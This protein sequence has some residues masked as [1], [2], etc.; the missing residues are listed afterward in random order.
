MVKI[1]NESLS[2]AV[3]SRLA[4]LKKDSP[5]QI[6]FYQLVLIGMC[7]DTGQG[8]RYFASLCSS[9]YQQRAEVPHIADA[10][11]VKPSQEYKQ[12]GQWAPEHSQPC[13]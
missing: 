3:S 1:R 9:L 11:H 12:S 8:H 4:I 7:N 6:I 5:E 2:S 10:Q 13:K